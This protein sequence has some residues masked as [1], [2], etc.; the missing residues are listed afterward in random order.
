MASFVK[1]PS[2]AQM[3]AEI[4]QPIKIAATMA[5]PGGRPGS[6]FM[7]DVLRALDIDY[8]ATNPASSCRDCTSRSTITR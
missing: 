1:P 6:D 2:A 5:E 4:G 7:V 3:E 8:V